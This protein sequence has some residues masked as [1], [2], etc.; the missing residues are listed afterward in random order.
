MEHF[1]DLPNKQKIDQ[2]TANKAK[3]TASSKTSYYIRTSTSISSIL[4]ERLNTMDMRL[5]LDLKTVKI[6]LQEQVKDLTAELKTDVDILVTVTTVK[7]IKDFK[8]D[9]DNYFQTV[10]MKSPN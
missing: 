6:D 3:S 1:P 7:S 4:E 10:V 5:K 8:T 2:N 9:M